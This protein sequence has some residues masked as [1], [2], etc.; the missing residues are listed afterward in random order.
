M[1]VY[2]KNTVSAT[3]GKII[4][5]AWTPAIPAISWADAGGLRMC[6]IRVIRQI[7]RIKV[8]TI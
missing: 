1:F 8:Q 7:R 5:F 2:V 6:Q 4:V 3:A